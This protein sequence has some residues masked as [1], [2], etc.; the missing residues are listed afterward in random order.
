MSELSLVIL[1]AGMGSRYGGLKQLEPVGPDGSAIMD[2]SVFDAI[3][4]GF[5]RL[6]LVIRPNMLEET[7]KILGSRFEPHIEVKYTLQHLDDVPEG[8]QIPPER[9]KPWGTGHAVWAARHDVDG[10]FVV[11]NADD[12]YGVEP[13]Q[14]IAEF[15]QTYQ[16]SVPANYAMVGFQ[17]GQ[18]LSPMGAV[19]RGVCHCN[20]EN[21]L[22][23][24]TEVNG[25]RQ[26]ASGGEYEDESGNTQ[27]L[28]G[29]SI[30]SMNFWGFQKPFFDQLERGFHTFLSQQGDDIKAEYYLVD[31][32][33]QSI[34]DGSAQ[35]QVLPT[36][37]N[38]CGI[39]HPDDRQFVQGKIRE[40]V[41]SGTY[42][43]QLWG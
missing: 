4:A 20:G 43:A 34:V 37:I 40:Y 33:H 29:N 22:E 13:F 11:I 7:K 8:F 31:P 39:T 35:I 1:A 17:L 32:V 42:P 16:I 36:G 23:S 28:L 2:Y 6:V 15:L 24:I 25:I 9:E 41:E 10:A 19:S 30:V 18:T 21:Q 26:I 14:S 27:T 3:R 12:Y 5:T 38:W